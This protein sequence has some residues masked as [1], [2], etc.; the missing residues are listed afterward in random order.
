[1]FLHDTTNKI[2]GYTFAVQFNSPNHFRLKG[3]KSFRWKSFDKIKYKLMR[4]STPQYEVKRE[5]KAWLKG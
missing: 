1:M 3:I 4:L 2:L 5:N